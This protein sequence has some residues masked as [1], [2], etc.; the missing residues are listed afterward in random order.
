MKS[1]N[2][3]QSQLIRF[4]MNFIYKFIWPSPLTLC[5]ADQARHSI[6]TPIGISSI[7]FFFNLFLISIHFR[8]STNSRVASEQKWTLLSDHGNSDQRTYAKVI[9]TV[10]KSCEHNRVALSHFFRDS[11]VKPI[12]EWWGL[13]SRQ[14]PIL[15]GLTRTEQ[16]S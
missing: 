4:F 10:F 7:F 16:G 6:E 12:L 8:W 14:I 3:K 15:L 9:R 11:K 1:S 13:V 5:L 2:F